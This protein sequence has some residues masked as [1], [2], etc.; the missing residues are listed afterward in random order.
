V[1]PGEHRRGRE[2]VGRLVAETHHVQMKAVPR[3]DADPLCDGFPEGGLVVGSASRVGG[4]WGQ[5]GRSAM[6]RPRAT[7]AAPMGAPIGVTYEQRDRA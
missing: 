7:V 5:R 2:A 3:G 1:K 4:W 6:L